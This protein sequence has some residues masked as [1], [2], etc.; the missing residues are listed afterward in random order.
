MLH[1]HTLTKIGIS[2]LQH[3]LHYT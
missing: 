3:M 1:L 2:Y